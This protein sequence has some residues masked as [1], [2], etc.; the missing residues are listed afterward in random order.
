MLLLSPLIAV[1][2]FMIGILTAPDSPFALVMSLFPLTAPVGMIARM[3]VSD[4]PVW[5]A[6]LSAGLQVLTALFILR[7]V[8]R[9][10]R[11]QMLLSGQPFT[12]RRYFGL[13][14]AQRN[15]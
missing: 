7:L 4:V 1:Y 12:L 10:F 15:D 2:I 3:T 14:L 6:V 5:Q 8:A 11:A 9:L 13:I